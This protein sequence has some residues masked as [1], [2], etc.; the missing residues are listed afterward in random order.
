MRYLMLCYVNPAVFGQMTQEQIGAHL[1]SYFTYNQEAQAANVLRA[2]EQSQMGPSP[3]TVRAAADGAVTVTD[4][5]P[6]PS[7]L[8]IG[9]LYILDVKDRAEAEAWAAKIPVI[10]DNVGS[11]A[12]FPLADAPTA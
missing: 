5:T 6:E 12:V 2:N 9:G 10:K 11:I 4:G 1:G 8:M 7:Q 3:F